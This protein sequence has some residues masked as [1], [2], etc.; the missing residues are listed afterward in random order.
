MIVGGAVVSLFHLPL[1]A[2][3]GVAYASVLQGT[4]T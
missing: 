3:V 2:S 4:V 1:L